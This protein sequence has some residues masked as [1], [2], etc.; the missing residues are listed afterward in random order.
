M[1]TSLL[2][3]PTRAIAT[4][5]L[6]LSSTTA[7][8]ADG[9]GFWHTDGGTL[10]DAA[11]KVVHFSGT[12]WSG[13]DSPNLIPHRLW[14]GTNHTIEKHLDEMKAARLNLIRLPFS[15][16][17]FIPGRKP[18]Q[19]AIDS[20]VN[21]D[22][23]GKT[24]LEILDRI[25]ASAGQ[26]GIRIILDYHRRVAG[27]ASEDGLWY[28][29]GHPDAQWIDNWVALV[30]RYK[31][32]PTVVGG[33][34]FNEVH[35]SVTWNADGVDPDH[36]WRWAL[37]RCGNAILAVNPHFLI[38]A[39]G[40][41]QYKGEGAWWGEVHTG[42]HD[43]PLTLDVPNQLLYEIHDYGPVVFDQPFHQASAGFP[44]NLPGFWDHL[45]GHL[46]KSGTGPVWVG[47]WGSFLNESQT[48]AAFP[49]NASM[50]DRAHREVNDW[51]PTMR[52]YIHDNQLSWTWWTWTNDSGDT[53]GLL[54]EDNTVNTAK[55]AMIASVT[56]APFAPSG[57]LTT[58]ANSPPT[59]V[60]TA[61][62]T[63]G[64]A[65]LVVAFNASGSSDPDSDPLTFAWS[66]GDGSA[67]ATG[68]TA[69]HTY[70][71]A[72]SFTATV[73]VSD[74]QGHS[75][76]ATR[77]ITVTSAG[78]G[79]GGGSGSGSSTPFSGT[80]ISLPGTIQA[81]NFDN[82]GEGVAYHDSDVINN[83]GGRTSD[84]VDVE[85]VAGVTDV[86]WTA[87]GEW[88]KY[89]VVVAS[90]GQYTL[91][92][93]VAS[94][95]GS[96]TIHLEDETGAHL[97]GS[98][99]VSSTGGWQNWTVVSTPATLSA[100]SHVYTVVFD[101]VTMG[102]NL[103]KIQVDAVSTGSGGGGGGSGG[104]GGATSGSQGGSSGC[105]SGFA[106]AI[107]MVMAF[108]GMRLRGQRP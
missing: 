91:G 98:I 52:K 34:L 61:T 36:N 99:A 10:R 100:G 66:F 89:S 22:L 106:V 53:G 20:T 87:T 59:A 25:V 30:T 28:D 77:A 38:C 5:V 102:A 54:N 73:T 14:G 1:P 74:G 2:S 55:V 79:G 103:D 23:L 33:D 32:N 42:E 65:P 84:G 72:G 39:Q 78:G 27:S 8:A 41:D 3:T 80:A 71:A 45:W 58:P 105:G 17:I 85:T 70:T 26:R 13:M 86:G 68:A 21:A 40:L 88:L 90:T 56:Y 75:A 97:G 43:F 49:D 11:G 63:T 67:T 83:G 104:G 24:C 93:R 44:G 69:S 16:E 9:D 37:K 81:E 46:F 60:M 92:L 76:P 107:S 35:A 95:G 7:M 47:E 31:N 15:S 108:L 19:S 4:L 94:D 50:P 101:A 18:D 6:A 57:P 48:V 51:F 64:T 82:G 62:P 29:G 96:A 12:N